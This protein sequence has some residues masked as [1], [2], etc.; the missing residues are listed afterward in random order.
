VVFLE[1]VA[2]GAMKDIFDDPDLKAY[3][4]RAEEE[5]FPKMKGSAISVIIAGKSDAKL[6]V[7][8]GAAILFDKPIVVV[9]PDG[10]TVPANLKRVAAVIVEGNSRDPAFSNLLQSA[11]ARVLENDRRAAAAPSAPGET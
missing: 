8:L 9:V 2:A 10:R 5:M 4:R 3:L 11:I 7:E 6:C 1:S